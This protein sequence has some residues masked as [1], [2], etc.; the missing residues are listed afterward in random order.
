MRVQGQTGCAGERTNYREPERDIRHEM[1]V[2]HVHVDD[3]GAAALGRR[4]L[5]AEPREICRKDGRRN[6]DHKSLKPGAR[7]SLP[8]EACRSTL[9]VFTDYYNFEL[10]RYSAFALMRSWRAGMPALPALRVRTT[11]GVGARGARAVRR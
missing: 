2:H 7:A 8:A 10:K 1:A 4:D 11:V 9:K 3:R 6:L 5:L